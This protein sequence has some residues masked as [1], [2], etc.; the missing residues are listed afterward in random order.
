MTI[1]Q[2]DERHN[3]VVELKPG[4]LCAALSEA[5]RASGTV[6]RVAVR[7]VLP[8]HRSELEA[9]LEQDYTASPYAHRSIFGAQAGLYN[10]NDLRPGALITG[11]AVLESE[12]NSCTIPN[13]WELRI[14]GFSNAVLRPAEGRA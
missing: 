5:N 6:E 8:V 7:G 3:C 11:P 4:Q 12:T 1:A 9:G 10:W 2:G 14:D 13:G